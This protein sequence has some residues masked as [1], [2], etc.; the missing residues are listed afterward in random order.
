MV[1]AVEIFNGL[2]KRSPATYG[3]SPPLD[4]L[5]VLVSATLTTHL[6]AATDLELRASF[7]RSEREY[8]GLD[9]E[10]I[11]GTRLVATAGR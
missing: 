2:A 7:Q 6:F 4:A 9:R 1:G 11:P 5:D 10:S 8:P 3:T